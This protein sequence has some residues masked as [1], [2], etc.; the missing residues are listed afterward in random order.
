MM[1][2]AEENRMSTARQGR[3]SSD[4]GHWADAHAAL[5][6]SNELQNRRALRVVA[7]RANDLSDCTEL[8]AMLGLDVRTGHSA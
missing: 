1:G 2:P 7:G 8:L 3:N 6:V 4:T 5:Q